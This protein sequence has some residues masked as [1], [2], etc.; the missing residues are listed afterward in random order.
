MPSEQATCCLAS[1]TPSCSGQG[2]WQPSGSRDWTQTYDRLG[3]LMGPAGRR[4]VRG[5]DLL[6]LAPMGRKS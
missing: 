6:F 1:G 4:P 2:S 3:G 5:G